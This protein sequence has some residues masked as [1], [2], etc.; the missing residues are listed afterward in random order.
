M[1]RLEAELGTRLFQRTTPE[2]ALT[3][4]GRALKERC[5][6]IF[7]VVDEAVDYVG[8]LTAGPRGLLRISGAI[9]RRMV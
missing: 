7:S 2:V 8:G 9:R 6:D 3:E 1:T 4:P 5:T